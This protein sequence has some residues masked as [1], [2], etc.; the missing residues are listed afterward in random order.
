[1]S[2]ASIDSPT[3]S[4]KRVEAGGMPTL[5]VTMSGDDPHV[6]F[7][8]GCTETSEIW[9]PLMHSLSF[10]GISSAALDLRGHGASGGHD[11]LQ[12]AGIEDYVDDAARALAV[13]PSVRVV[14]GHSMGG[15]V[16]QLLAARVELAHAVLIASCPVIGM[17]TDGIRMA[18]R[19]PWT[20]LMSS[21]RRSFR[22]LYRNERVTRSLLF[23]PETSSE[24]VRQFMSQVQEDSWRA[25]NEMNTLLP[26]AGAVRCKVTVIGGSEDF[27]VSRASNERT[28]AAYGTRAIYM[29]KCAHMVPLECD[30]AELARIMINEIAG[31]FRAGAV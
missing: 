21:L 25:G 12:E 30:P 16:T 6:L 20:F 18:R 19:H 1:M 4:T 10:Y 29:E 11:L 24:A 5:T 31:S 13:L 2:P 9:K 22:R 14:V 15:L 27:M 23:H 28:A 17:K 8:H 26:N 3:L 7:I